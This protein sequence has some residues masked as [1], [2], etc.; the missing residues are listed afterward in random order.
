MEVQLVHF[1]ESFK[2][3]VN[4]SS[5]PDWDALSIVSV[6]FYVNWDKRREE[7][8]KLLLTDTFSAQPWRRGK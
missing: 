7:R 3:F 8:E 5:A 1:K 4:A 6:F 2:S